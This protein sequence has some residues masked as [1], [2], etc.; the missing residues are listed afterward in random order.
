MNEKS[1]AVDLGVSDYMAV[2][3]GGISHFVLLLTSY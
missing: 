2:L 3:Y 1:V